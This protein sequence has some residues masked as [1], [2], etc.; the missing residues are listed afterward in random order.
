MLQL[1]EDLLVKCTVPL[2]RTVF[3]LQY[4]E[5]PPFLSVQLWENHLKELMST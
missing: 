1:L 2:L 3:H 5:N 4:L